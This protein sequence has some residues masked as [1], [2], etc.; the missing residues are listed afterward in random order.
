[1]SSSKIQNARGRSS[2]VLQTEK[3]Q[4]ISVLVIRTWL[5]PAFL[6]FDASFHERI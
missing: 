5:I 3:C 1:M 6:M 2:G 4:R